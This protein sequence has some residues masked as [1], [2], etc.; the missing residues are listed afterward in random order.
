MTPEEEVIHAEETLFYRVPESEKQYALFIDRSRFILGQLW[1]Q[2]AAV[3]TPTWQIAETGK[4]GELRQ[5]AEVK[6]I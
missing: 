2:K 6:A 5:F 3:Q 4:G 1:R